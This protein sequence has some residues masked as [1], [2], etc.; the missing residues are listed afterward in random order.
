MRP[1]LT[2]LAQIN[3]RNIISWEEKFSL[4]IEYVNE[5]NILMDI[6]IIFITM[7]KAFVKREGINVSETDTM[8]S[9]AGSGK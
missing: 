8:P 2:G 1:G 5:I 6:K 7:M 3:G 4:D 9:F